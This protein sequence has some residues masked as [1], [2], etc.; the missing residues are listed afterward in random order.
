VTPEAPGAPPPPPP[1][2][3]HP[4]LLLPG[5]Q[6]LWKRT[7]SKGIIHR[8]ETVIEAITNMRILVVDE[9]LRAIV[10]AIPLSNAMLVVTNTKRQYTGARSGYGQKGFYSSV[11]GGTSTTYGDIEFVSQGSVVFVL[12]NVRDPFGCKNLLSAAIRS[13]KK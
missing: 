5:E 8:H 4:A 12:K 2:I 3:A 10:R 1:Q 6:I 11:G 13:A 7:F 9:V